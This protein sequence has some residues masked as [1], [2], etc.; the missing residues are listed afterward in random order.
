MIFQQHKKFTLSQIEFRLEMIHAITALG[1]PKDDL[2]LVYRRQ[3]VSY[4]KLFSL[5]V[6]QS[7]S[8]I[9]T[10]RLITQLVI[11]HPREAQIT[12]C[13][14]NIGKYLQV[15]QLI[16]VTKIHDMIRTNRMI[17][18]QKYQSSNSLNPVGESWCK[19]QEGRA[20][21]HHRNK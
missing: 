4:R 11:C 16:H 8:K 6:S 19:G 18:Y 14:F 1:V 9:N 7:H 21:N 2:S 12:F 17:L 10:R 15:F 13:I 20:S 3:T 5:Y